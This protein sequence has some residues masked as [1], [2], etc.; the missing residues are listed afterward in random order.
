MAFSALLLA[1]CAAPQAQQ[2]ADALQSY[3]ALMRVAAST[4]NSGDLAGAAALYRHAHRLKPE[5]AAPLIALGHLLDRAHAFTS[6][7]DAYR[8]ALKRAPRNAIALRGLGNTLVF[9][10]R[11]QAAIGKFAAAIAI[12]PQSPDILND[13]GVAL[14]MLGRHRAAQAKYRAGLALK[15][16]DLGLAS[17]LGLS[18][19]LSGDYPAALHYLR[20]LAGNSQS[21]A[22]MREDLALVYGLSGDDKAAAEIAGIDLDPH[23]V[24][25]NLAYY[26]ALRRWV[27]RSQKRGTH[28]GALSALGATPPAVAQTPIS[29]APAAAASAH[30]SALA[31]PVTTVAVATG[32]QAAR[33]AATAMA[34]TSP[35]AAVKPPAMPAATR[36]SPRTKPAA[37]T[38]AT[39]I[40]GAEKHAA[41]P[42]V[43][44]AESAP[45]SAAKSVVKAT[46]TKA[47]AGDTQVQLGSYRT[48]PIAAA[49]WQALLGH[50][51]ALLRH[52]HPVIVQVDLGPRGTF[53]RLR[54]G[55]FPSRAAARSFCA[56][57]Q[58]VKRSC[59]VVAANGR[60]ES[61]ATPPRRGNTE[62]ADS[63][64]A[65]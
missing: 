6:A 29:E 21:T 26:K 54:T 20:P 53:E 64:I 8:A 31:A 42:A 10:D 37:A 63:L 33:M 2:S 4:A 39:A 5:S 61:Q 49:G 43:A 27:L 9:L 60:A 3:G 41:K 59:L 51:P 30:T 1:G 48:I 62:I 18:L 32:P 28:P 45:A 55:P 36:K 46:A 34:K 47:K 38:L 52:L 22:R 17:N 56:T 14:D 19:A 50:Y 11:P 58:A 44:V 40:P 16:D 25:S 24:Q 13:Y 65:P 7:E 23:S 15:P 57:L 35:P 12:R